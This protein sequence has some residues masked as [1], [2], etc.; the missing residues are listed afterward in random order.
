MDH[1]SLTKIVFAKELAQ[2]SNPNLV[3]FVIEASSLTFD[4]FWKRPAAKNNAYHPEISCG[5]GGLVRHV[6]YA[7]KLGVQWCRAN[8]D[9]V[10]G[11]DQW[12]GDTAKT[13]SMDIVIAALILHDMMKEGDPD[14]AHLPE[15]SQG[16]YITGCH[17]MDMASAINAK[18]LKGQVSREHSLILYA[19]ACHMGVWT[20]D[21]N[22]Y[23]Q[24]LSC[25]DHRAVAMLVHTAD[26]FSS[27]KT[28][29][30][31]KDVWNE[32]QSPPAIPNGTPTTV[33]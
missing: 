31:M 6:K 5:D 11:H 16:R 29:G 10:P 26:Y 4:G 13:K 21:P 9:F 17:G 19:I 22:F 15:R 27:R 28:D 23:P 30:M 7:I 33:A 8:D 2:I 24:N 18:I 32:Y 12:M 25:P 14:K 3:A 1:R 20:V